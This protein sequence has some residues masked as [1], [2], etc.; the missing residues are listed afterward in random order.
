MEEKYLTTA[1]FD[2]WAE[3]DKRTQDRILN[4]IDQQHILNGQVG[5]EI[6]SLKSFNQSVKSSAASWSSGV[7][8]VVSA[9]TTAVISSFKGH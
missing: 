4:H 3:A 9:V 1:A 8:A 6:A 2:A 5:V 7:S